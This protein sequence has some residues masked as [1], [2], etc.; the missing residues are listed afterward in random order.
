MTEVVQNE[1][2]PSSRN[3]AEV[4]DFCNYLKRTV[5]FHIEDNEDTPKSLTD[6]LKE[7]D[8]IEYIR[9]FIR[10]PQT[11]TLF[12]QRISVK[13]IYLVFSHF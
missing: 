7:A 13:G 4:S 2:P 10:D 1:P 6:C 8:S 5:G 11:S 3:Y 12:I 9:K